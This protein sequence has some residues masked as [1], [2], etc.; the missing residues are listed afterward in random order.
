MLTTLKTQISLHTVFLSPTL[1]LPQIPDTCM[2]Y[3]SLGLSSAPNNLT[4]TIS[5]D[6]TYDISSVCILQKDLALATLTLLML[7]P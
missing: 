2:F 3:H 1:L 6:K 4:I 5:M 7:L